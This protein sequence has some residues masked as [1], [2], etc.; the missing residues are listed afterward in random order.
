[1]QPAISY[2]MCLLDNIFGM[3][4]PRA[5]LDGPCS[6]MNLSLECGNLLLLLKTS[7]LAKV[8]F[9]KAPTSRRTPKRTPKCG[10]RN[11]LLNNGEQK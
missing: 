11:A 4:W 3:N 2:S 6:G 8:A 7:P 9:L 1:M 10:T 5:G